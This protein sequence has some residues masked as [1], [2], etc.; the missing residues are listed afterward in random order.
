MTK[1]P[2]SS[3]LASTEEV[4]RARSH[5]RAPDFGNHDRK[6][7]RLGR[8]RDA[9]LALEI[10]TRWLGQG[11]SFSHALRRGLG[12]YGILLSLFSFSLS[13][14]FSFLCLGSFIEGVLP[15]RVLWEERGV[16]LCQVGLCVE[17][18]EPS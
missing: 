13:L 10:S 6:E 9:T 11:S 14:F 18:G 12:L 5:G 17:S 15:Q 4:K 1:G 3:V 7:R 2:L 16:L 8:R